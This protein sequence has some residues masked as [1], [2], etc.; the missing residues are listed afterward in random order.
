MKKNPASSGLRIGMR[1]LG[2]SL[3]F[4][5][6]IGI[7]ENLIHGGGTVSTRLSMGLN[8]MLMESSKIGMGLAQM[9][10]DAPHEE[11][12][13]GHYSRGL[14]QASRNGFI[15]AAKM[16]IYAFNSH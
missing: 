16:D 10:A 5:A 11:T 12:L 13:I 7:R 8:R 6:V 1:M 4:I 3:V 15:S 9:T 14:Y 2:Y